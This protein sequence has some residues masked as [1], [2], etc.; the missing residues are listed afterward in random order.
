MTDPYSLCTE[1]SC[2]HCG[3]KGRL[4]ETSESRDVGGDCYDESYEQDFEVRTCVDCGHY[5]D[6]PTES[7]TDH[8]KA[9]R[10]Q[11]G[12]LIEGRPYE[13]PPPPVLAPD[14]KSPDLSFM[15]KLLKEYYG[16]HRA[17]LGPMSWGDPGRIIAGDVS[18]IGAWLPSPLHTVGCGFPG[19]C[20]CEDPA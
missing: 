1:A 10:I 5:H 7:S 2:P 17:T 14:A 13:P 20:D 9:M 3:V 6:A 8:L 12:R 4:V 16:P 19:D 18:G 11:F 15:E